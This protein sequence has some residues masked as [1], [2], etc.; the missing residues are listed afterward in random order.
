MEGQDVKFFSRDLL[1]VSAIGAAWYILIFK[2]FSEFFVHFGFAPVDTISEMVG[3]LLVPLVP[4]YFIARYMHKNKEKNF[5]NSWI[6][7]VIALCVVMTIG[8][9]NGKNHWW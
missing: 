9:L 7:G 4:S 6:L 3:G 8:M 2:G 1:K 5:L